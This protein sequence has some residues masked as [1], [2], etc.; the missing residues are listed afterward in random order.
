[1]IRIT[2]LIKI[3]KIIKLELVIINSKKKMNKLIKSNFK[4]KWLN[5]KYKYQLKLIIMINLILL[6]ILK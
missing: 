6:T 5:L 2:N 4:K 3:S 1:M